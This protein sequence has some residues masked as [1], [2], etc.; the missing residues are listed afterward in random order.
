VACR[1]PA[2]AASPEEREP[3]PTLSATSD[4]RVWQF[5]STPWTFSTSSYVIEGPS[6]LVL[7]DLQFTPSQA[8]QLVALAE[9]RTGKKVVLGIV[10]HANPDKFNGT[11]VLQ[12]RGIR[13]VTSEQVRALVPD[14][15][16]RRTEA[17]A[18][19][20]APD[21]PTETPLP[22]S[23]GAKT[24]TLEAAGL[25]LELH[26]LGA[27]CSEAH[28]VV[29]WE[30]H[31]FAGDLVAH[32]NHAWLEIGKTDE[33]LLRLEE[34]R[35][36][37]PRY[38]HPGRGASGGPDLLETQARYLRDV[39]R[40]VAEEN[41]KMPPPEG[42]LEKVKEKIVRAYPGYGF[43]VFLRIGLPAEW[44]RQSR[45]SARAKLSSS[46]RPSSS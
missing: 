44:A 4:R 15:F 30:G 42:A 7:V 11:G 43:E 26:V 27:G 25:T 28:V 38:V 24:T 32:R 1:A 23:F 9:A 6:G 2:P 40:F 3:E 19:R 46:R 12:K 29:A 8:E 16:R 10:L 34:I 18:E 36:R 21:W 22:E 41:P 5:V 31:V 14:V 17:F 35:A 45:G 37:K 13:V 33:W 20:Y 39:M